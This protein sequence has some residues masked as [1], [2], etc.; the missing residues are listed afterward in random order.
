M[1]IKK[2]GAYSH[3]TDFVFW[4]LK[5]FYH[6]TMQKFVVDELNALEFAQE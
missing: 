6:E 5:E 3:L 1:A 2:I 4:K